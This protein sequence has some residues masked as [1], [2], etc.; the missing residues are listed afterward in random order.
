MQPQ[1]KTQDQLDILA[2]IHAIMYSP[3]SASS[4]T[5]GPIPVATANVSHCRAEMELLGK[6]MPRKSALPIVQN[7]KLTI[8]PGKILMHGTNLESTLLIDLPAETTG[9]AEVLIPFGKYFIA[10]ELSISV[11]PDNTILLNGVKF[12]N[13][14]PAEE[15]PE[16]PVLTETGE[17]ILTDSDLAAL[18]SAREFCSHDDELKPSMTG[19]YFDIGNR[20]VATDG[21]KLIVRS[22]S[23]PVNIK[24]QTEDSGEMTAILPATIAHYWPTIKKIVKSPIVCNINHLHVMFRLSDH[25]SLIMR[26]IDERFPDYESVIPKPEDAKYYCPI[27]AGDLKSLLK[28][29]EPGFQNP[30]SKLQTIIFTGESIKA[31]CHDRDEDD[32]VFANPSVLQPPFTIALDHSYFTMLVNRYA[33]NDEIRIYMYSPVNSVLFIRADENL[34]DETVL[35]MPVRIN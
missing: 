29:I 27:T 16:I 13:L 8:T 22:F 14:R 4:M 32:Q 31:H 9:S 7:I 33:D 18:Y 2:T 10:D 21:Y 28:S 24:R 25:V 26:L 20:F 12:T 35:L 19:F 5:M 30:D 11:L 6:I 1:P 15:F 23:H 17:F 3:K 34:N